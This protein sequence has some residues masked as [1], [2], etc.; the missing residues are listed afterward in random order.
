MEPKKTRIASAILKKKNKVGGITI[1]DIKLHYKANEIKT[2]PRNKPMSLWSINILQREY[3]IQWSKS[4][5]FN[6]WYWENWT[7]MCKKKK[8]KETRPPTYT[9]HQNKLKMDKRLKYKP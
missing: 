2:K 3:E 7:G 4:R 8:K 9:I 5:L 1:P 6:K